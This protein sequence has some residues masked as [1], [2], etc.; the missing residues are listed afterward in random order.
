[1]IKCGKKR[2]YPINGVGL[3]G[4]SSKGTRI[5]TL[6]PYFKINSKWI[7]VLNVKSKTIKF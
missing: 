1:M 5:P 2:N 7:T 6:T 4:E 3:A